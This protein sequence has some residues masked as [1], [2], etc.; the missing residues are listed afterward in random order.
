MQNLGKISPRQVMWLMVSFLLGSA[1][2]IIPAALAASARQDAWLSIILA[3]LAGLGI[4]AVYTALALRFPGQNFI[5][6]SQIILGKI[7][8]KAVGLIMIWFALH[9]GS[10]VT[11]NFGDFL[12]ATMLQYTPTWFIN[13]IILLLVIVAVKGGL[14]VVARVNDIM[15]PFLI[16]ILFVLTVLSI[17]DMS[18]RKIQPILENGILPVAKG[19]LSAIGFPF[20]ETMLFT[21]IIPYVNT[22]ARAR[23]ALFLGGAIGGLLLL[24]ITLR[25]LLVLGPGTAKLW[26]PV[27]EA[28]RMINLFNIIQR[29]EAAVV[30]N[31]IGFGFIKIT[32]CFYAFVLGLAQWLNLKDYK[33]LLLPAGVLMVSLSI[34]VYDN[35]VEEVFFASMIWFPYAMPITFIIPLVMLAVAGIRGQGKVDKQKHS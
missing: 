8:G 27:L 34:L 11:R 23:K 25:T 22:P 17:P 4:I 24:F 31:W 20:A 19:S 3:T 33:P 16:F 5:Q 10:L 9:L 15:I 2:L 12:N 18:I 35:Y 6:Y 14:E 32:V 13:A 30:I 26:Y 29:V 28:V 1:I 21:M 7:A